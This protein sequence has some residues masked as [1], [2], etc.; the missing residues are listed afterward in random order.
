MLSVGVTLGV[1]V[2]PAG[3]TDATV[4]AR[5]LRGVAQ[6][7]SSHN[8]EKLRAPLAHTLAGLRHDRGSTAAG[9]RGRMLAIQGFVWTLKGIAKEHDFTVNDSGN[10]EAATRDAKAADRYFTRGANLL[11]A[12]G[13]AFDLRIGKVKGH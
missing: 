10:V 12:A 2:S 5:L 6:I 9:R 4:K 11:R 3:A 1:L 7:R 13:R 8:A